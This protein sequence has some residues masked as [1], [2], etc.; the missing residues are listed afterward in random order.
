MDLFRS[1]SFVIA[2]KASLPASSLACVVRTVTTHRLFFC[3]WYARPMIKG[4][5]VFSGSLG[6]LRNH[7]SLLAFLF[8]TEPMGCSFSV[9]FI[10]QKSCLISCLASGLIIHAYNRII[11]IILDFLRNFESSRFCSPEYCFMG[12]E[13]K[14]GSV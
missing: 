9:K 1:R 7:S 6:T 3:V 14:L 4:R 12:T 11:L 13:I 5:L 10:T 8:L 2:F